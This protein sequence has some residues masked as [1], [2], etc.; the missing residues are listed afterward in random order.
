MLKKITK[1]IYLFLLSCSNYQKEIPGK[2]TSEQMKYYKDLRV[3]YD[4]DVKHSKAWYV[5]ESCKSEGS[6]TPEQSN[7]HSPYLKQTTNCN[8]SFSKVNVEKIEDDFILKDYDVWMEQPLQ[9]PSPKKT[10]NSNLNNINEKFRQMSLQE[11]LKYKTTMEIK[12]GNYDTHINDNIL[13]ELIKSKIDKKIEESAKKKFK[14]NI[15]LKKI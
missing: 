15:K 2:K 1:I 13:E 9:Q 7:S 5:L 3:K 11:L 8:D 6:L 14:E 10:T 12:G 4:K